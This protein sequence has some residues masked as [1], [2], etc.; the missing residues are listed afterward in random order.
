MEVAPFKTAAESIDLGGGPMREVGE[1]AVADL[2]VE[3]EGLAE[4]DS[5]R[6]VAVGDA[7]DVHAYSISYKYNII[8]VCLYNLHDYTNETNRATRNKTNEFTFLRLGTSV[9]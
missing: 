4:E 3:T 5:G 2:A 1:G 6:G 9:Y 7:G 8:Q